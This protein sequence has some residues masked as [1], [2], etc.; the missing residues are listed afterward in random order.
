M[1]QAVDPV[2]W[3]MIEKR[4]VPLIG[5]LLKWQRGSPAKGVGHR[6]ML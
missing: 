5:R 3:G 4:V 1:K 2:E 6:K